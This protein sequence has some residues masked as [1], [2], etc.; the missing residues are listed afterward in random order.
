[1]PRKIIFSTRYNSECP[2]VVASL[3][4]QLKMRTRLI[5][6]RLSDS[7]LFIYRQLNKFSSEHLVWYQ[8]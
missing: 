2:S 1:M 7:L 8:E 6:T 4:G 3:L 5:W